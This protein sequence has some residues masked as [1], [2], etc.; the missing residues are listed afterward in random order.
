M[1]VGRASRGSASA[2]STASAASFVASDSDGCAWQM[3]ARSSLD[4]PNSIAT[5]PSAISSDAIGPMTCM[6]RMRSVCGVGEDLHEA[7]GVAQ[8]PRAAVGRERKAAG[9]VGDALG[10]QLLLGLADPGDLRR[11]VDHPRHRVEV[12][13]AV[14]AGDALGDRD[15]LLLGLV[16]EH[17]AAHDVADRPDVAAGWSGTRRRRRRSRARRARA[18]PPRAPSPPVCGTRPIERSAGRTSRSAPCRRRRSYATATSFFADVDLGD[19]DAR[20][21]SRG[22]ACAKTLLR[23]L[24]DRLVGGAEERRQRFEHRHLARPAGA[25]RCPSRGR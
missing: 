2:P 16:R 6:P 15:A 11:R 25:R 18:R 20:C 5:T 19:R 8:R 23:L 22:P 17:R 12:D 14:L 9:P 3:R 21:G 13:V 7:R 24:R 1:A 10:L 4:A